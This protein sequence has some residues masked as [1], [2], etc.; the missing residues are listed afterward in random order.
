MPG[1]QAPY[2][3]RSRRFGRKTRNLDRFG[4]LAGGRRWSTPAAGAMVSGDEKVLTVPDR[5]A[6]TYTLEFADGATERQHTLAAGATVIGRASTCDLVINDTS[7][8]RR[9]AQLT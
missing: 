9:H 2:Q 8:S 1:L 4:V 5:D 6:V 3:A 7:V